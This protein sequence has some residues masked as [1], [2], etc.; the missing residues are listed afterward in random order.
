MSKLTSPNV[1]HIIESLA[2]A[3]GG[4]TRAFA[5]L[6][7]V[8][9]ILGCDISVATVGDRFPMIGGLEGVHIHAFPE[10]FPSRFSR[11]SGL[12]LWLRTHGSRFDWIEC[13]GIWNAPVLE[14]IK[15]L[16]QRQ[17]ILLWPHG[18]LDPYDLKKHSLG[19]AVLGRI[20][21]RP[22]LNQ[23][24][25]LCFTSQKEEDLAILYGAK[26]GT[27]VLPLPV[28]DLGGGGNRQEFRERYNI[29]PNAFVYLFLSRVN[30]K[31]GLERTIRA[32]GVVAG[33][34]PL[35][36]LVIAGGGEPE[37]GERMR[38]IARSLV[39]GGERV[40][41][42]GHVSGPMRMDC[43][44]GADCFLLLSD[45]ENFGLSTVEALQRGLPA[46]IS[47]NVYISE[48]LAI[49]PAVMVAELGEEAGTMVLL[50]KWAEET[51]NVGLEAREVATQ[52]SPKNLA[53][54]FQAHY[55]AISCQGG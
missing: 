24:E 28:P 45:N 53:S 40:Q 54:T 33:N 39:S 42:I 19:K 15:I 25:K 20:L 23:V 7:A 9:R 22:L 52:Y 10:S 21:V 8:Q 48:K 3:H 17:K 44:A 31:K 41:F 16:G 50:R 13:H 26:T 2:D 6:V 47:E 43:F 38:G 14:A 36:Y 18:S 34:D 51:M 30:Y 29:P 12:T 11:S 46:I 35:A 55:E 37:Y 1:L 5:N 32:F 49:S 27:K 4:L